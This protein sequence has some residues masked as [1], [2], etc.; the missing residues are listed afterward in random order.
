M[1]NYE[2]IFCSHK[3]EGDETTTK[4]PNCGAVGI[5]KIPQ[6]QKTIFLGVIAIVLVVIIIIT[7]IFMYPY[8]PDNLEVKVEQF[9]AE[10]YVTLTIVGYEKKYASNLNVK[11][12][13]GSTAMNKT[14]FE[15]IVISNQQTKIT[16]PIGCYAFYVSFLK[17]QKN[18][19]ITQYKGS[20]ICFDFEPKPEQIQE[21]FPPKIIEIKQIDDCKTQKWN[22]TVKTESTALPLECSIDNGTTFSSSIHYKLDKGIYDIVVKDKNGLS[23]KQQIVLS[24]IEPCTSPPAQ[25][26]VQAWLDKLA[27]GDPSARADFKKYFNIDATVLGMPNV[28]TAYQLIV[29]IFDER[30]SV[31]ITHL[32]ISGT[33]VSSITVSQ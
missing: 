16:L 18:P 32:D 31:K 15:N 10:K 1:N 27:T 6:S 33:R 22:I 20:D 3:F 19:I 7:I 8:T 28:E 24:S 25:E 30:K 11:I 23:A 26:E 9:K 14:F 17:G 21:A 12:D 29:E 4:C 2:C 5:V 13:R